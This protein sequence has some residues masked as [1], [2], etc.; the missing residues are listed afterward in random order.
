MLQYTYILNHSYMKTISVQVLEYS[1]LT[2]K[3]KQKASQ[4]FEP[5]SPDFYSDTIDAIQKVFPIENI[6]LDNY[7]RISATIHEIE[8][9]DQKT[10]EQY[11]QD[12]KYPTDQRC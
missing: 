7:F 4:N 6:E 3:A 10:F 8:N 5:F 9:E 11:Q 1:E 12:F 2:E